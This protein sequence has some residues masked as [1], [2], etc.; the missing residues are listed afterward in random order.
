M[1]LEFS[2]FYNQNQV[3]LNVTL[4]RYSTAFTAEIALGPSVSH[5]S[6]LYGTYALFKILF[7]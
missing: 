5:Q 2:C 3:M 6:H 7:E 4:K 1:V